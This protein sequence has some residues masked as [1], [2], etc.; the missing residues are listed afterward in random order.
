MT[1]NTSTLFKSVL[2]HTP[3]DAV[4]DVGSR[5]GEEALKFRAILPNAAIHAFEANPI[6]HTKMSRDARLTEARV[7]IC[8]LAASNAEGTA[9]FHILDSEDKASAEIKGSSG[10]LQHP[11]MPAE[12]TVTVRTVRLDDYVQSQL[13]QAQKIALWV[14][15]EGAE[16]LVLDGIRGIK[17]RVVAVHVETA[18]RPT[19]IGQHTIVELDTLMNQMD[20]NRIGRN[21]GEQAPWG[22]AVYISRSLQAQLPFRLRVWQAKAWLAHRFPLSLMTALRA[23]PWLFKLLKRLLRT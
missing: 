22:D 5:D 15:V 9:Q 10:L 8:E 1:V 21:F 18:N 19:R 11:T 4:L 7:T 13:R 17:D 2:W 16:F 3:V 14:D 23:R 6:N 20:F 12:K